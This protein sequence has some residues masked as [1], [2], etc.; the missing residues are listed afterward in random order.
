MR[1]IRGI[2]QFCYDFLIGDDWKIAAGVAVVMLAGTVLV[3]SGRVDHAT[4]SIGLGLSLLVAFTT[5]VV[6]DCRKAR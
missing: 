2:G 6:I 5:A 3:L 4:L 1:I